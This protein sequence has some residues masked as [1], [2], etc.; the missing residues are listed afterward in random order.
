MHRQHEYLRDLISEAVRSAVDT[1]VRTHYPRLTQEH[2]LTSRI[3]QSIEQT[4]GNSHFLGHRVRII[5]QELPDKG[6]GT[7]EKKIGADLYVAVKFDSSGSDIAKGFF[8]QAKW[9]APL[10]KAER[11]TLDEQCENLVWRS[12]TGSFVWLYSQDGAKVIAADEVLAHPTQQPGDLTHHDVKALMSNV[13]DC[14]SGDRK[15]VMDG[16]FDNAEQLGLMLRE[17]GARKGIAIAI[18]AERIGRR[19]R[20]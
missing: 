6:P 17:Y 3:A 19:R 5:V 4:L 8:V 18:E 12:K 14:T 20:G 16:I 11:E 2:Q 9:D 7:L 1:V 13:F 15:L 10:S